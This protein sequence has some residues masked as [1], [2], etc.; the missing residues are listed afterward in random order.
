MA[1]TNDTEILPF[2]ITSG[3]SLSNALPLGGKIVVG[4]QMPSSWT[5]AG[6]TFQAAPVDGVTF[7]ELQDGAG[8][9]ITLAT[10]TA[11]IVVNINPATWRA[12]GA[13][14]IRSGTVGAPVAQ[15]VTV[16]INVLTRSVY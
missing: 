6:L 11:G 5:A 3:Q 14:K 16:T 8:N 9:P 4:L 1:Q 7:G 2:V 13:L 10:V 12:I 15:A